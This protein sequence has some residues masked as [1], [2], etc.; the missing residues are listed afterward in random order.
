M[1]LSGSLR[2]GWHWDEYLVLFT[3]R[4]ATA[5]SDGYGIADMLPGYQIVGLRGWD[6]FIVRNSD[7]GQFTVQL[8]HATRSICSQNASA[9][10]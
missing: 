10:Y 2:Q 8:F 1:A 5:A 9:S 7:G 3:D 6:D 4:V